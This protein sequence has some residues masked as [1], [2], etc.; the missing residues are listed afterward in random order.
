MPRETHVAQD[1]VTLEQKAPAANASCIRVHSTDSHHATLKKQH[2]VLVLHCAL[3]LSTPCLIS[4]TL[5][6]PTRHESR[7]ISTSQSAE[8]T[9]QRDIVGW[10]NVCGMLIGW[11]NVCGMLIGAGATKL[12]MLAPILRRGQEASHK[13]CQAEKQTPPKSRRMDVVIPS[14]ISPLLAAHQTR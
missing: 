2:V 8:K 14:C 6:V 9:A 3:D 12:P 13:H 4:F 5:C 7:T 10:A 11:A 1:W